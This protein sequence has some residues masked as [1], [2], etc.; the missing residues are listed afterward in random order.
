[1]LDVFIDKSREFQQIAGWVASDRHFREKHQFRAGFLGARG[2]LPDAAQ[3][4]AE[5]PYSLV[6]LSDRYFHGNS[7]KKAI[8]SRLKFPL[9]LRTVSPNHMGRKYVRYWIYWNDRVQGPFETEELRSLRAFTPELPVCEE[10][11]QEWSPAAAIT[12]LLPYFQQ[13]AAPVYAGGVA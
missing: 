8:V 4:A 1:G 7:S 9:Q 3:V 10:D 11:R 6:D 13:P 12:E 5:V 2:P